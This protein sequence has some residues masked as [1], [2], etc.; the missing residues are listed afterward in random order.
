MRGGRGPPGAARTP[1]PPGSASD[2]VVAWCRVSRPRRARARPTRGLGPRRRPRASAAP[3]AAR[4][5][6]RSLGAPRPS[7]TPSRGRALLH[8]FVPVDDQARLADLPVAV[9]AGESGDELA[10]LDGSDR[11]PGGIEIRRDVVVILVVHR[12]ETAVRRDVY[13]DLARVD[14]EPLEL[15]AQ[16]GRPGVGTPQERGVS[17]IRQPGSPSE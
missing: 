7:A 1:R 2:E 11:D 6:A 14:R 16:T 4:N 10:G 13:D 5:L 3:T 9:S 17:Q 8:R 12:L 15:L